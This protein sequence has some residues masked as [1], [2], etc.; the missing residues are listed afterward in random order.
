MPEF[1][2]DSHWVISTGDAGNRR[3]I[4]NILESRAFI[5]E[6]LHTSDDKPP[7]GWKVVGSRRYEN[8]IAGELDIGQQWVNTTLVKV[9]RSLK[10]EFIQ[11]GIPQLDWPILERQYPWRSVYITYYSPEVIK[12]LKE[13]KEEQ[14][15]IPPGWHTVGK[16]GISGSIADSLGIS[17]AK[18]EN[19]IPYVLKE[20][21][22]YFKLMALMLKIRHC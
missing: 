17:E 6:D 10:E 11:Q 9:L 20:F 16:I 7:D 15:N 14:M 21:E 5:I 2:T 8:T 18:I 19:I 1:N 12:R 13:I 22:E 4:K 3:N